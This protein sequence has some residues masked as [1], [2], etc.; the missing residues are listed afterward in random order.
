VNV[1]HAE[2]AQGGTIN[3]MITNDGVSSNVTLKLVGNALTFADGTPATG[4]SY[5]N[6]VITW[7]AVVAEGKTITVTATQTDSDGNTS[8]QGSDSA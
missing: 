4:Y 7:T 5:N 8:A 2:L 3:L 1:N 6:G